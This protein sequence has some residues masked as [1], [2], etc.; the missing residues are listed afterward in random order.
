MSD[1]IRRT[2][3]ALAAKHPLFT[4]AGFLHRVA[5]FCFV[6]WWV[7]T[8]GLRSWSLQAGRQRAVRCRPTRCGSYSRIGDFPVRRHAD[9]RGHHVD[10]GDAV[11]MVLHDVWRLLF[12]RQRVDDA[13]D[14]CTSSR[15]C[16]IAQ[17][18]LT[19]VLHEHQYY[20][21]GSLLF[22]FTVFY[23]YVTF[24]AIFHHLERQHA[25]GNV[26]VRHAR[27]GHLVVDRDDH[28]LR[29]FLRAVPRRCCGSM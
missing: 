1:R 23:A 12:R 17:G 18:V 27:K 10:E 15:W 11:S 21:I 20:F 8:N 24:R 19:D 14:W 9:A 13:G 4:H 29:P 6:V 26:L 3:H 16:W 7:L 5:A 2:D 25:G 22:A 28:Y